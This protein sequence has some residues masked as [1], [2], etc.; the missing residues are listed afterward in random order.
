MA[1][2]YADIKLYFDEMKYGIVESDATRKEMVDAVK[3]FAESRKL[4]CN[5]KT[6]KLFNKEGKEVGE[7]EITSA[8]V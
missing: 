5:T 1:K 3:K 4:T 6:K 7:Y 2:Y 8:S